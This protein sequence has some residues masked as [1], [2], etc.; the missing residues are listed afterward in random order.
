MRKIVLFAGQ[1]ESGKDTSADLL[2]ARLNAAVPPA[3][4]HKGGD[5]P[6]GR[7]NIGYAVRRLWTRTAFALKVKQIFCD[8]FGVDLEFVEKWKRV[9]EP[10]PGFLM[11]VRDILIDIGNGFRAYCPTVWI[12]YV[13]RL[14]GDLIVSDGR[15]L[16]E[17]RAVRAA[18][19]VVALCWRPGKENEL[20]SPS[21]QELRPLLRALI[22]SGRRGRIRKGDPGGDLVDYFLVN[23]GG[24][25]DLK[26]KVAEVA[27][28][29]TGPAD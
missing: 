26:P 22:A 25:A 5:G 18:G 10:P 6:P 7:T 27:D 28:L 29:A 21:E 15:Y 11:P 24:V 16:N 23:D 17:L 12:D 19:G 14:P 13:L 3:R 2:A 8:T 20:D 4:P 1:M 9:K